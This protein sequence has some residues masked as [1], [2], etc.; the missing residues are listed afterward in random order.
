MP[1]T[2]LAAA[3]FQLT[4][5]SDGGGCDGIDAKHRDDDGGG[6]GGSGLGDPRRLPHDVGGCE[7]NQKLSCFVFIRLQW[8]AQSLSILNKLEK[9]GHEFE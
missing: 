5:G 4:C 7:S 9:Y 6:S 2:R 3:D 8:C 1:I